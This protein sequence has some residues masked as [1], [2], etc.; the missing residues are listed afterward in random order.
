MYT[1]PVVTLVVLDSCPI[2][3][4]KVE[5]D[6]CG[7]MVAVQIKFPDSVLSNESNILAQEKVIIIGKDIEDPWLRGLLS[8]TTNS[9]TALTINSPIMAQILCVTSAASGT[10]Q[11]NSP[12]GDMTLEL[13]RFRL[14][15]PSSPLF[16]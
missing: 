4:R 15:V 8:I 16:L 10:T 7:K 1:V 2:P 11:Q 13:R 6:G 14:T 3:T 5:K 9:N 12:V